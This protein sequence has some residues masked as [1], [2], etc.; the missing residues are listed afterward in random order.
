[1]NKNV[2]ISI[3]IWLCLAG[4]IFYL[5]DDIQ[6]PNKLKNLVQFKSQHTFILTREDDGGTATGKI[7]ERIFPLLQGRES[8]VGEKEMLEGR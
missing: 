5:A 6:N 8:F 3:I 7:Y 4:V 2:L 1:M